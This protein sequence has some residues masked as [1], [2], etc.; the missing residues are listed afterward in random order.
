MC[1]TI[2]WKAV[3][4]TAD[5]DEAGDTGLVRKNVVDKNSISR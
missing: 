4:V 2:V 5:W 1:R 3:V